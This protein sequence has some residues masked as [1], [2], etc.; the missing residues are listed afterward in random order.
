M[1]VFKVTLVVLWLI[2]V[3][4]QLSQAINQTFDVTKHAEDG[5]SHCSNDYTC[6]TWF[7][8]NSQNN[9]QCGD[10]HNAA[11]VCD[12]NLKQS[13]VLDCHCVTY[14]KQSRAT[15]LGLCFYNC[16]NSNP[17]KVIDYVYKKLPQKPEEL[18][19]NSSCT[20]FHRTGL[21][22]GDCEEELSPFVL[23]YNLSCV[24]CPEGSKNWWKFVLAGFVPLTFFYFFV[25]IFNI[26]VTSSH[27]HGV[28]WFSQIVSMPA[29]VR[30]IMSA[31]SHRSPHLLIATRTFLIFYS[32][33]NLDL[34][35]SVIP[36]ICLNVTTLQ[37]LAVD[38]LLVLH[39]FMLMML[40][41]VLIELYDRRYTIVIIIWKPFHKV[42]STFRKSWDIRTSV[43]DSFATFFLL[44]YVKVLS[45]T[46]DLLI[47]TR[48]YKLG[49]S[50]SQSTL[51]LYYS[52]TVHY[53]GDE[54]LPYAIIAILF[55]ILF[56][57]I[58]TIIFILYPFQFFQKFISLFPFNWHFLH[59]F[60]DSFQ[61]CYKD[62]TEPRTFDCRWFSSLVLLIR[63]LL[64]ILS[65]MTL[66]MMFFVYGLIAL[67]VFSIV[68]VNIQP[69]KNVATNYF[70]TDIV[71]Y[72]LL[73]LAYVAVTV[74]D[75][76]TTEKFVFNLVTLV[77]LF[78]AA[79]FPIVY[80]A[81]L[82][83]IWIGSRIRWIRSLIW[84]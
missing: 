40:S 70:I 1:L 67:L 22:C 28:V 56:V 23:S 35:R 50:K 46:A 71:F 72:I 43:I 5:H 65:G 49:T 59:A 51:R 29:F 64:F 78:L 77:F 81:F 27:L 76:A 24:R 75:I 69:F 45:V 42:L 11:V 7:I 13:A 55:L 4:N 25:I 73:C 21:L 37:A 62:G 83:I 63:L 33:W 2:V 38:Y 68:A 3:L 58:P 61:G 48:V 9:C 34:L 60:V 14:D 82:V 19:N 15:Y 79:F 20:H 80:I 66:S 54:H 16:Q 17:E 18:L 47:P 12:N 41:Y 30:L 74:R 32:F 6:P 10:E 52:P 36:D 39:P 8:C 84:N 44:S 57:T 53:F 26:N 31:L